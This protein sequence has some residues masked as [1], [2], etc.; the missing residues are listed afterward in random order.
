MVK[1]R[2]QAEKLEERLFAV[3]KLFRD[4]V[5]PY[6]YI[7]GGIT[8]AIP[9]YAVNHHHGVSLALTVA[10]K[11]FATRGLFSGALTRMNQNISLQIKNKWAYPVAFLAVN[12][13]AL[14][15]RYYMHAHTGT[16]DPLLTAAWSTVPSAILFT[17][18][19]T[20]LTRKGYN[21]G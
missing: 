5:N 11:E 12:G 17:P 8:G 6:L 20:Y 1:W 3:S 15:V 10:A 21:I 13:V 4:T 14:G 16:P 18:L 7:L 9:A 19:T 2:K